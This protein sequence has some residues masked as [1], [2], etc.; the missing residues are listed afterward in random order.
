MSI[1]GH[2]A[3]LSTQFSLDLDPPS[4]LPNAPAVTE[5]PT[6]HELAAAALENVQVRSFIAEGL[7]TWTSAR[8]ERD[9]PCCLVYEHGEVLGNL[10]DMTCMVRHAE[11]RKGIGQLVGLR[12]L[13][14]EEDILPYNI[15]LRWGPSHP[16]RKRWEQ[17]MALKHLLSPR[18]RR[19]VGSA[20][21]RN[22]RDFIAWAN[23]RPGLAARLADVTALSLEDFWRTVRGGKA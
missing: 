21:R 15:G 5:R 8:V 22:K 2:A 20:M 16:R 14:P 13:T 23:D 12:S 6:L 18:D 7:M 9:P 1:A 19:A 11:K 17:R 4:H 3:R 10:S